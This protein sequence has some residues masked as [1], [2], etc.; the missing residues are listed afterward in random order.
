[1]HK[2]AD[3]PTNYEAEE[4]ID[5]HKDLDEL[6]KPMT[7]KVFNEKYITGEKRRRIQ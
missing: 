4:L 5:F 7:M 6:Y 1:M 2:E 3:E